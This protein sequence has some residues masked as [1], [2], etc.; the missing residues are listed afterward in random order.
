[1]ATPI[2]HYLV[3]LAITQGFAGS[4]RERK[5]GVVLATLALVPD[6]DLVA[7]LFVGNLWAF[8]RAGSHSIA[9]AVAFGLTTFIA[10]ALFRARRPTHAATMLFFVYLSHLV[11]DSMMLD[12]SKN[13]GLRLLWPIL[14][15]YIQSPIAL[16]PSGDYRIGGWFSLTNVAVV[17]RELLIFLPLT[18]LV[19][20]LRQTYAPWLRWIRWPKKS[21]WLFAGWFGI[22]VVASLT[23]G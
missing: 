20:T 16:L 2:G 8:H 13:G 4:A 6:L 17:T 18:A 21:A 12:T 15:T 10:L 5:Q 14:D 11:L 23:L 22:A 9:A 1:M 19:I 7:G 3:G